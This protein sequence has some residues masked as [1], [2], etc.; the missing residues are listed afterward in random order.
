[1]DRVYD[2]IARSEY[3]SFSYPLYF[4]SMPGPLKNLIDRCNLLWVRNR[5][6]RYPVSGQRGI[7]FASAGSEYRDMFTPSLTVI[8]H[9]MNSLGGRLDRGNS[10]CLGGLDT[11]KGRAAYEQLLSDSET[12][13]SA[14][15]SFLSGT[16]KKV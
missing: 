15:V 2:A 4:S 14:V 5:L 13:S 7:A 6:G 9:L 11:E 12:L 8:S 1:M 3:L 10:V 16:S